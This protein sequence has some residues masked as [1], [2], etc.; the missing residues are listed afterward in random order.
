MKACKKKCVFSVSCIQKKFHCKNYKPGLE[1][2]RNDGRKPLEQCVNC[3][4]SCKVCRNKELKVKVAKLQNKNSWLTAPC[5][6]PWSLTVLRQPT[7]IFV[8]V[9]GE[10]KTVGKEFWSYYLN[11]W[12]YVLRK[13]S[14]LDNAA[15]AEY[16]VKATKLR[17]QITEWIPPEN[18][19]I[20]DLFALL[21]A[22]RK[23]R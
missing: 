9:I 8:L 1:F 22:V 3:E 2:K 6:C 17:S 13:S 23:W 18:Q 15:Q 21:C 16:L 10:H 14:Y 19:S 7:G 11:Q 20:F 5:T 4:Q 12:N